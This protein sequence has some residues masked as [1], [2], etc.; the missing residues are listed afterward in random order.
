MAYTEIREHESEF[1]LV[2]YY[3]HPEHKNNDS[4]TWSVFC[5]ADILGIDHKTIR[6]MVDETSCRI[7]YGDMVVGEEENLK[8]LQELLAPFEVMQTFGEL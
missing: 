2:F 3:V 8:A 1:C 7:E 4:F 5:I 6:K